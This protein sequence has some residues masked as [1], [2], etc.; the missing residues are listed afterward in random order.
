MPPLSFNLSVSTIYPMVKNAA[1]AVKHMTIARGK[2]D[3]VRR[4]EK[5]GWFVVC[6]VEKNCSFRIRVSNV[7]GKG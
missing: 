1:N 3:Y 6:L 7:A 4:S 5:K 2:S